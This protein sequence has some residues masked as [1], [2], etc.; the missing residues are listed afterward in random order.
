MLSANPGMRTEISMTVSPA[1]RDPVIA[2]SL[3]QA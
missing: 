2:R 3:E 1:D